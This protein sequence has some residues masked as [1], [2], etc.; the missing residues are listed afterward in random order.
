M[1][2]GGSCGPQRQRSR[3]LDRPRQAGGPGIQLTGLLLRTSKLLLSKLLE[4]GLYRELN[5]EV[6]QVLKRGMLGV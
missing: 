3:L 2:E 6:L 5:R 4:G 1:Q